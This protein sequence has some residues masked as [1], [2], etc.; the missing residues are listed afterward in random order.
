MSVYTSLNNQELSAFLLAYEIGELVDFQGISEGIENTNYFVTTQ[1]DGRPQQFVLTVFE[2]LDFDEVP[3]FLA[4]TAF[5]AEHDL[6]C[7]HPIADK[8]GHYL[9]K[10]KRKPAALV[11]RLSGKGMQQPE[12]EQSAQIGRILAKLHIEGQQFPLRKQNPRGLEWA[13]DAATRIEHLLPTEDRHMLETELEFQTRLNTDHLPG[14]VIH[15]DLFRD[16]ALYSDGRLTGII[17][18]YYACDGNYLYDLAITVNDW[19]SNPDGSLN[20]NLMQA[21]VEAYASQRVLTASEQALWPA[22]LRAGAL[23]FWLSRLVDLHF[24]RPGDLTHTHDP[25]VFKNIL[26]ERINKQTYYQQNWI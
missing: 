23:R 1:L 13:Q 20:K 8:N 16:N 18:F 6:P 9:L 10:L 12:P 17:D 2:S 25:L 5:L 3:Y 22:M 14:G 24:P 15:A 21:L 11:Q 26:K 19:C 7:A 4:L